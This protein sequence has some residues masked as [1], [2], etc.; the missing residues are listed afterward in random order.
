MQNSIR[1]D[2]LCLLHTATSLLPV[3][4]GFSVGHSV[5]S[6]ICSLSAGICHLPARQGWLQAENR[7]VRHSFHI[8][9]CEDTG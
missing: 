6:S 4:R 3:S 1:D 7:G 8:R 5:I 2:A 9:A